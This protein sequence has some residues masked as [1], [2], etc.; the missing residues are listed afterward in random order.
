MTTSLV[1]GLA[2]L[3]LTSIL[4][5]WC[6]K[7]FRRHRALG[8]L[9]QLLGAVALVIVACTHVFESLRVFPQMGWGL[10]RSAGHYLDLSGAVV[11]VTLLP[12]GYAIGRRR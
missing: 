12:L 2:A 9:L 10:E 6:L 1:K 3:V 4:L 11:G 8:T 7:A 5:C